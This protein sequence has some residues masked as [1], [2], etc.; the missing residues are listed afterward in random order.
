VAEPVQF[1]CE[2]P[3]MLDSSVRAQMRAAAFA[4]VFALVAGSARAADQVYFSANTNVTNIS[5]SIRFPSQFSIASI[6]QNVV[7]FGS[8]NFAPT[9]L[10]P[11]SSTNYDDD[12]EM[13]TSDPAIVGAFKTK[14]DQM[15]ND[16]TTEPESIIGPPPYLKDW[17]DACASEPTGNCSDYHTL[18][19]NPAPMNIDRSRLE[20]DNPIPT[21]L[22][23]GQGPDFN[24]RLVQEINNENNQVVLMVYRLEVDN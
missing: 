10:A 5:V 21:D 6:G 13:F 7:E 11:N 12:S 17:N 8:G 1:S 20:L 23:F 15:W 16:T 14:F 18:Y 22:I 9:E 4:G 19:P 24:N 2:V 3:V